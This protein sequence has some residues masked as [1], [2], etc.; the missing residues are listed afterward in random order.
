MSWFRRVW[1]APATLA[2]IL[3][4]LAVF[5]VMVVSSRHIAALAG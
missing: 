4:N 1:E 5:A 3:V 2:L